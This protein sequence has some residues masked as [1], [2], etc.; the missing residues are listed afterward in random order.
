MQRPDRRLRLVSWCTAAVLALGAL[1]ASAQPGPDMPGRFAPRGGID[2]QQHRPSGHGHFQNHRGHG[3]GA[4]LRHGPMPPE[5]YAHGF[6]PDRRYH[7]GDRLPPQYRA[8]QYVVQDWQQRRYNPPPR[9]Y[10]Y[11]QIGRGDV[12]LV[13]IAS[14]VIAS[15]LVNR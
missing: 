4:V 12:V 5:P 11:V 13:A 9:G 8:P 15:I 14:G 6:R 2:M 1:P 7:R 3:H 10:R